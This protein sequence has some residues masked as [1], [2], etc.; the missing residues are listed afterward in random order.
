MENAPDIKSKSFE[1]L[2]KVLKN[3]LVLFDA[4]CLFQITQ[5][6]LKTPIH[7][8]KREILFHVKMK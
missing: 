8:F 2:Q 1:K 7:T 3:R 4:I 6:A 5:S